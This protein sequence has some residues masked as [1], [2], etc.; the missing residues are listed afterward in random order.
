MSVSGPVLVVAEAPA[1]NPAASLI[2]ALGDAGASP[3]VE[4]NWADAPTAFV[5]VKPVA[6]VIAEAGPPPCE[7]SV[8]M[9]CLQVATAI[10]PIVPVLTPVAADRRAAL[11]IALAVGADESPSR[12]IARLRSALRVRAL[13][14]TVLRRIENDSADTRP[15]LPTG[16]ALDD[17]TVLVVGRGP[18]YSRLGVAIGAQVSMVGALSIESAAAHLAARDI[19]GIVVGDGLGH[20]SV[21][22]FL[23]V[24]AQDSDYRDVPL[25]VVPEMP[26]DLVELLPQSLAVHAAPSE[27]VTQLLP[28]V[29]LH[30][31]ERRLRRVLKTLDAGGA[32][33]VETGILTR[34]AF[35]HELSAL[36]DTA[37]QTG[38]IL[39]LA[40]F[41]FDGPL[42]P[43]A[44]RDVAR[45][46]ARLIRNIDF[47]CQDQDGALLIAFNQV[48]LKEA[49]LVA[50][51]V[52]A[53]LK[54]TLPS[55]P[56]QRTAH[57]TLTTRKAGDTA[58]TLIMRVMG[59]QAVAAE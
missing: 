11:P 40:R 19:D 30:A 56:L 20:R 13:H 3:V 10:G 5:A 48:D 54:Q 51:R 33:D 34:D 29:R 55:T 52:A 28:A 23:T 31:F 50:R 22:A 21:E 8:R 39:S 15:V 12:L 36:S 24:L 9:L 32:F 57:V 25:A 44:L 42:D 45:L 38:S 27:L 17:A 59:S 7:A 1:S 14:E 6:I 16:D 58:D 47:A 35:D 4:T 26:A 53:T 37:E 43:R 18:L 49:H 41:A 46:A 2:A